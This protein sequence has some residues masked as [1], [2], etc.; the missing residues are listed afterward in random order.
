MFSLAFS[1]HGKV[2]DKVKKGECLTGIRRRDFPNQVPSTQPLTQP[3]PQRAKDTLLLLQP[4][5][6]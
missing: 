6:F 1:T 3:L 5:W 2:A 4:Q